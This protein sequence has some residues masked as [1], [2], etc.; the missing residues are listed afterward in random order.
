MKKNNRGATVVEVMIV[1]FIAAVVFGIGARACMVGESQKKAAGSEVSG[2][3]SEMGYKVHGVSCA[4]VDSDGDGYVS[5]TVDIE[6]SDGRRETRQIECRGA[7]SFG[8]GCRDPKLGIP[9][10]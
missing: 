8:H 7:Y 3:A 5:C 6:T 9:R 4:D 10:R 2:W 1:V